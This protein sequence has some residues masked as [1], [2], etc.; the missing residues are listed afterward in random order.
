MKSVLSLYSGF[1][2]SIA[3]TL[4]LPSKSLELSASPNPQ[5][6]FLLQQSARSLGVAG[7]YTAIADD[8]SSF[9][10]NPAG[11]SRFAE[12]RSLSFQGGSRERWKNWS[13]G[14]SFVDGITEDPLQW[15]FSFDTTSFPALRQDRY[16]L[17][18]SFRLWDFFRLG[19][20]HHLV[21]LGRSFDDWF[22]QLDAGAIILLGDHFLVG[23]RMGSAMKASDKFD[24]S[25]RELRSGVSFNSLNFRLGSDFVYGFKTKGKS[26]QTGIEYLTHDFLTARAGYQYSQFTKKHAYSFGSS[27]KVEEQFSVD[28]GFIDFIK[29]SEFACLG[30]ISFSF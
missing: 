19:V 24:F 11:L 22:Y 20:V 6:S 13:L 30:S 14:A 27:V 8:R 26:F 2:F 3:A 15:G 5:Q 28:T 17:A 21:Y 25:E 16:S 7:A 1:L 4:I 23:S 18:T 29:S 10:L 9:Y 12:K